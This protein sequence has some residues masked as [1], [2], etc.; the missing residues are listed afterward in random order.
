MEA[1]PST[2]PPS[3]NVTVPVGLPAPD[4][5]VAV[6]FTCCPN[7]DG[8]GELVRAVADELAPD[9]FTRWKSTPDVLGAKLASPPYDTLMTWP[10]G[11]K[12]TPASLAW[13]VL[14]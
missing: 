8:S 2:T 11:D 12:D 5:T 7:V 9:R 1:E 10:P 4:V 13:P 3:M 14:P 6:N